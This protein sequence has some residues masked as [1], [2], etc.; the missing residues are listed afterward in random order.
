MHRPVTSFAP[1]WN[2]YRRRSLNT[3]RVTCQNEGVDG[4]MRRSAEDIA[5]GP[6]SGPSSGPTSNCANAATSRRPVPVPRRENPV[7][8]CSSR[9]RILKVFGCGV[10]GDVIKFV[11][12]L[13]NLTFSRS[14]A[15]ARA[16]RGNRARRRGY[17]SRP[18]PRRKRADLRR[19]SNRRCVLPAHPQARPG[20]RDRARVSRQARTR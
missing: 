17:P 12:Q 1:L 13:E 8:Q 18:R 19:K 9:S 3:I 11:Q 7:V 14:R 15:H 10:G 4:L 2:P 20:R 16:P 5:S 6:I